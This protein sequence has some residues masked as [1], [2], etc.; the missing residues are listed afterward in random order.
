M[1]IGV[2]YGG[3]K[4]EAVYLSKDGTEAGRTRV[5][6][7]RGDYEG[8]VRAVADLV[9][10]VEQ[11]VGVQDAP[12]G[13]GIPG[14]I[15]PHTGFVRNG[16]ATW[17]FEHAFDKDLGAA[18]GRPV[19]VANDANCLVL[20]EALDG[21][22]KGAKSVFGVILGTGVGC[23]TVIDGRILEGYNGIGGEWGHIPLIATTPEELHGPKCFCGRHG[24]LEMWLSGPA[25]AA[26]FAR[27]V[28]Q[29]EA[30]KSREVVE[31]AQAGDPEARAALDRHVAR[32]ARMLGMI[33]N[34]IDPEVIVLGGGLSNMEHLYTEVPDAMLPH[35]FADSAKINLRKAMHGDSSGVRG[36]ARLW[37]QDYG[38]D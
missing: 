14:S 5:P 30:P 33:V 26:D 37:E 6:T 13:V 9:R 23:G 16:N 19:R 31:L 8:S 3:T 24:C 1:G 36:A 4:I 35:V 10:R 21:V 17:L 11:Q 7:P 27:A 15:S 32:L 38:F 25:L 18:L 12:V 2:D 22:A 29:G 28:E 34:I 20:S